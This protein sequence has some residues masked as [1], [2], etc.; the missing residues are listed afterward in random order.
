MTKTLT[1]F[2]KTVEKH[3][4]LISSLIALQSISGCDTMP[5]IF[6]ICKFKALR[7]VKKCTLQLLG[8][9]DPTIDENKGDQ[10]IEEQVCV[11]IQFVLTYIKCIDKIYPLKLF[12]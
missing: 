6:G 8:K 2:T 11:I 3:K 9:V 7:A 1:V 4:D 10:L 5:I 12:G